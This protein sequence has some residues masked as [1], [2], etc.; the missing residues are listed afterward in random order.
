MNSPPDRRR[1]LISAGMLLI[2]SLMAFALARFSWH[3][4]GTL[5]V[6]VTIIVAGL[7][8]IVP[9]ILVF[10]YSSAGT[11]PLLFALVW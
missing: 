3:G 10:G 7:F 1:S 11:S 9:T 5:P 2:Y 8:W 4:R 6:L